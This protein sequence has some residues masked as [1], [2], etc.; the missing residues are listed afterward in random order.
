M[1]FY[2]FYAV[3]VAISTTTPYYETILTSQPP[4]VPVLNIVPSDDPIFSLFE[5][6]LWMQ[7]PPLW[8]CML[9]LEVS[10]CVK[11]RN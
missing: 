11:D 2:L 4:G 7:V 5:I 3:S 10:M 1:K 6:V 9:L 8:F